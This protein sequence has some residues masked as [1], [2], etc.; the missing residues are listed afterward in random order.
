MSGNN[1]Y[2]L[3]YFFLYGVSEE[4]KQSL[5][6]DYFNKNNK[7][8]PTLLSSYSAE[9]KTNLFQFIEKELNNK[10][11]LKDNIFPK[12]ANFL[13]EITFPEKSYDLPTINLKE[14]PFN[15]YI[16]EVSSF[17]Q[18]PQHFYH[19]FQYY[20]KLDENSIDGTLLNLAVLI[21]YENVTNEDEL[22][23]EKVNSWR[24]F[25][26]KS[27]YSNIYVPKAL[28]LVSDL[29]IFNLM[30]E[31]L[32]KLYSIINK[33]YTYFPI[34]QII[35]NLF[36]TMNNDNNIQNK[37]KL[38]KEPI[39][40]FCD[41]NI[42]FFFNL[43]NW[44]DLF[45]LAEYYLCSKDIIIASTML[46]NLFPIY[47]ILMTLFF[48]LN[49]NNETT[50]YKLITPDEKLLQG[51][52]FGNMIPTFNLIYIEKELDDKFLETIAKI[53]G[54]VL[55]YQIV[56]DVQNEKEN[57]INVK[58][59]LLK[60]EDKNGNEVFSKINIDKYVT[61]IEKI[62][63]LNLDIKDYL[64]P[65]IINDIEE[66]K[67]ECDNK[68]MSF[69][70][71]LFSKNKKYETLRN[72][73]IG[74]FIKFFVMRLNPIE[75]SK[76]E[77]KIEIES[78]TFK[79]L[80][81]DIAAN[82][83][84]STLYS[85][86]QSD[87]IYKNTIINTGVFDNLRMK[88][89][90][91]CDYFIKISA[92]DQ[93]RTYFEPKLLQNLNK[94]EKSDKKDKDKDKDK[95]DINK[96]KKNI[97]NN[98]DYNTDDIFNINELFDYSKFLSEDRNYFYY[99]NRVYLY[100]LQNPKK[101]FFT[102][103][104]GRNYIKHLEYYSELTKRDRKEDINK[105]HKY[106][107]LTYM[108]FYGEKFEL[109]FGQFINKFIPKIEP[110]D[111][112]Q[113]SEFDYISQNKNY[114]Q[115]YKATLDEAEI[116][117]DLF[118][119]QIIPIENKKELAACAIALYVLIYIINLMSELN[120]NNPHNQTLKEIIKKKTVKL[121]QLLVKTKGYFG[122]FD[123]LI[124]LL[125]Q[126]ISSRQLKDDGQKKFSDLVM[127]LLFKLKLFPSIIIILMNNH[128]IS[129][130]FRVIKKNIEKNT[131]IR[132]SIKNYSELL[133]EGN[134]NYYINYEP[135]NEILI[136]SIEKKPH[137]HEY[138]LELGIN[139]DYICKEQCGEYLGFKI[140]IKKED[141]GIDEIVNNPRY[142]IIKLLKKIIDNKSLFIHSYNNF[143][144][145]SQIIILDDLYF[146][147]GFFKEK[148]KPQ[149]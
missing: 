17:D 91:L 137:E 41:L 44:K 69:F 73:L 139:D 125:Y 134:G 112:Y 5:K 119:T 68:T 3:K 58:K 133:S 39:L 78:M 130:D 107:A 62:G 83:L 79:Q 90:I 20:F 30:K 45:L 140:K 22:L 87:L 114:E 4:I 32:E 38:Y 115:Y 105:I 14:N 149:K 145:I 95:D 75:I 92:S 2:L 99:I 120:N 142:I 108:I 59:S 48:P 42:S 16:Y 23:E 129:M 24:A 135:K 128:N 123:F 116:F 85:T 21:F 27:K 40:P 124:T 37:L 60:A 97:D 117:Y 146:K 12:K 80:E 19:C 103:N 102:I 10:E 109:H 100:S 118:I 113:K 15:Q 104:Q 98:I 25:L 144:D 65:L 86:P 47:Y 148:I 93:K 28:I 121:Y 81:N 31:I 84:L 143:N 34:E 36:D 11:H 96:K 1:E 82:D 71:S 13:S 54:D 6:F 122:K 110:L 101:A 147:I 55:I 51:T 57:V 127:N 18:K 50:F 52:L 70:W 126:V 136:Y 29:P 64:I 111:Q 72:H 33:K 106:N 7:I 66:I 46:E 49:N 132:K 76:K 43:F 53:K 94:E 63:K 8:S 89:I 9:G 131:K 74:L 77:G 67:K 56:K 88:K 26:W 138:E 61:I 35:I 141:E